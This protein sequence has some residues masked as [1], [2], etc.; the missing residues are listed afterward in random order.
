MQQC[1]QY[2]QNTRRYSAAFGVVETAETDFRV[3]YS[4]LSTWVNAINEGLNP[5]RSFNLVSPARNRSSGDPNCELFPQDPI[6]PVPPGTPLC[7]SVGICGNKRAGSQVDVQNKSP[8][9][10][11]F[12]G[13]Y[14]HYFAGG[15]AQRRCQNST[16][17]YSA[18]LKR[19]FRSQFPLFPL[20]G[21]G[22]VVPSFQLHPV[23]GIDTERVPPNDAMSRFVGFGEKIGTTSETFFKLRALSFCFCPKGASGRDSG[24]RLGG[25]ARF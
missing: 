11:G 20:D 8:R 2:A 21:F 16:R 18:V 3:L 13:F 5:P 10:R 7:R 23:F 22:S 17:R 4:R 1:K 14:S 25:I 9:T 6:M 15:F 24:A 12:E 19:E